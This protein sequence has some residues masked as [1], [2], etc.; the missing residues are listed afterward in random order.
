MVICRY[1]ENGEIF[2]SPNRHVPRRGQTRQCFSFLFQLSCY[3]QVSF[4]RSLWHLVFHIFLLLVV[5]LLFQVASKDSAEVLISVSK[6][7]VA[8]CLAKKTLDEL[9]SALSY[10]P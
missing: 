8:T 9:H 1:M 7:K 6:L 5:I 4:L 2:E 3:E 10:R